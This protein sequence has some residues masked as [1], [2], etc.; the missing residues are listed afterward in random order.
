MST[1]EAMLAQGIL[2]SRLYAIPPVFGAVD[3]LKQAIEARTGV[4]CVCSVARDYHVGAKDAEEILRRS[5]D[6]EFLVVQG[7][8]GVP[9]T[10]F[11][12]PDL[13]GDALERAQRPVIEDFQRA[14]RILQEAYPEYRRG[15]RLWAQDQSIQQRLRQ[16]FRELRDWSLL[17]LTAGNAAFNHQGLVL[18]M[19]PCFPDPG[20]FVQYLQDPVLH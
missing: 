20:A 9:E 17:P 8:P 3:R 18:V 11:V 13:T 12:P 14:Y 10:L 6:R 15:E 16:A 5:V 4:F 2:G 19:E 1:H 7:E